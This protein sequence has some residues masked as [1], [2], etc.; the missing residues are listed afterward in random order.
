M[1]PLLAMLAP[2]ALQGGLGYLSQR[3]AQK[4]REKERKE[5]ERKAALANLVGSMGGRATGRQA[6]AVGAAGNPLLAAA[7]GLSAD[8]LVQ[9]QIQD[10]VRN[11][12]S[13]LP[14][15]QASYGGP[16]GDRSVYGR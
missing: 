2:A 3:S 9:Q 11:L 16:P 13:R 10:L 5:A 15:G 14:G 7:Q 6:G 12:M 8:P 1:A 4:Q